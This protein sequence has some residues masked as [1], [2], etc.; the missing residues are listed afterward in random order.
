MKDAFSPDDD[1]LLEVFFAPPNGISWE[2]ITQ[3]TAPSALLDQILPWLDLLRED[4]REGPIVLPFLRGGKVVGWYGAS[5]SPTGYYEFEN[6]LNAWLGCS[7]LKQIEPVPESASYPLAAALRKR[8]GPR[9]LQF[10]GESEAAISARLLDYAQLMSRRP[11]TGGTGVRPVGAIRSDFDRALIARDSVRAE[12]LIEEFKLTGRLNEEN[13][14]YLDVRLKAGLGYWEA[15]ARAPSFLRTLAD[16]SLP[17]QVLSDLIEALYRT[18][19]DPEEITGNSERLMTLFAENIGGAYPKLFSSRKGIRTPRVV[20]AFMLFELMQQRPDRTILTELKAL[21]PAEDPGASVLHS[22]VD[23]AGTPPSSEPSPAEVE[24]EVDAAEKAYLDEQY[25]RAFALFKGRPL[26]KSTVQR[27]VHCVLYIDTEEARRDFLDRIKSADEALLASLTDAARRKIDAWGQ[28]CRSTQ[29]AHAWQSGI[30]GW[31][32]WAKALS[33]GESPNELRATLET[34]IT[35]DTKTITGDNGSARHFTDLLSGLVGAA[36]PVARQAVPAILQAFVPDDQPLSEATRPI[37]ILLFDLI[38]FDERI[39]STDLS[40]LQVLVNLL[41]NSGLSGDEYRDIVSSLEDVQGRVGSY[42]NLT[43]SLDMAEAL[44]LAP[45][46]SPQARV[47]RQGF[48]LNLVGQAQQFAHRLSPHEVIG[49]F[50]LCPDFNIERTDLGA[51]ALPREDAE[52]VRQ[53]D[54]SGKLIGIYTLTEAAAQR[55]RSTLSEMFPGVR[56]ET[57]ADQV[58]SPRLISLAKAADIFVFAWKSSSHQAYYC[59]KDA[60]KPREP[61]LPTGKG[62]ASLVRAVLDLFS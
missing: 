47:Q 41:L 25:D 56:V 15:I 7:Y 11:K 13:L 35:W 10:S 22:L 21:I 58:A 18:Y 6:E 53:P 34:C 55:A 23:R 37:A 26:S 29:G 46:P 9:I 60:M 32:E 1:A 52:L 31:L 43:W 54:L 33:I 59:V 8:F 42:C 12:E 14:R 49:F 5:L 3:R 16:L 27:Q 57:N 51:I 4:R 40:L 30:S 2:S 39:T 44:A 28:S 50:N 61:I 20:K 36:E 38:A 62:T 48:F 17:Q 19:L 24:A 45:V